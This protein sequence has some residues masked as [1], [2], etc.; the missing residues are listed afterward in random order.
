MAPEDETRRNTVS[1]NEGFDG[2]D[3]L[4]GRPAGAASGGPGAEAPQ[5]VKVPP[6]P[7]SPQPEAHDDAIRE[8]LQ[9]VQA[10]AARIDE[11]RD[12]PEPESETAKAL[13]RATAALTQA[14]E[15]TRGALD[16]AAELAAQQDGDRRLPEHRRWPRA[17]QR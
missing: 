9:T 10:T 15:D 14:V 1:R 2:R 12:A 16:K 4:L 6:P 8:I 7:A 13:T 11:L 17:P 5:T 3:L